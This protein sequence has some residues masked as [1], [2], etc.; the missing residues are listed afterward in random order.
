VGEGEVLDVAGRLLLPGLIDSHIHVMGASGM[1]G[2]VTRSTD[3]QVERIAGAGVTTVVSPLGADC[4]SRVLPT[5]LLRAAALEQEGISAYCYTGGWRHPVP[6][7]TGDPQGDV[8]LVDRFLGVKVAISEA[9]APVQGLDELCRLAHA[10][11]TG[12]RLAGKRAVLH[13]HVGDHPDGLEPLREV[14]RRTGVPADRIVATHANRNPGLWRQALAYGREGG[15][16]DCTGMQR[17]ETGHAEAIRPSAALLEALKAGVPAGRLTLSTD[18]G[19]GY[20]RFDAGGRPAGLYMAGPE[21]LLETVRELV[22]EGLSW[23]EAAAFSTAHPADLLGLSTKGR[24]QKGRDADLLLLAA[25]GAIDRVYNRGR[26]LVANG[27]PVVQGPFG[28]GATT[29]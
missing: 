29:N 21:S 28:S 2:P 8:A 12:G 23:G 5:L 4:L 10:A 1:G 6:T 25:E 9:L 24:L 11:Y 7:L 13:A 26:L 17:P 15:S 27:R 3:L 22:E 19:A 20:T 16:V 14:I 18:S